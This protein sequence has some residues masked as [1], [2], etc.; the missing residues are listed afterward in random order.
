METDGSPTH[1]IIYKYGFL[2]VSIT[3][4]SVC[5]CVCTQ[6]F[7][8]ASLYLRSGVCVCVCV[9]L[10]VVCQHELTLSVC[11]RVCAVVRDAPYTPVVLQVEF[12]F[13]SP[14]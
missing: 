2:H 10:H 12:F 14:V 11:I 6:H 3:L 8:N 9:Y 13:Y 1:C 7:S 4:H 5:V